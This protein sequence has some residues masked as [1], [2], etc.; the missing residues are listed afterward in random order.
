MRAMRNFDDA[1]SLLAEAKALERE[2]ALSKEALEA[3]AWPKEELMLL[4]RIVDVQV[5]EEG[6]D[7]EEAVDEEEGVKQGGREAG[8]QGNKKQ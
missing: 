2:G 1:K 4:Q 3:F 6:R 5:R 7:G 8:R